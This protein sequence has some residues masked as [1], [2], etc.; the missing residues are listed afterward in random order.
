[1]SNDLTADIDFPPGLVYDLA[2]NSSTFS[3]ESIYDEADIC[4]RWDVSL[5][6]LATLKEH[7]KFVTAVRSAIH[8]LRENGDALR[9]KM[10]MQFE[11]YLETVVPK[12]MAS[13]D[14]KPLEKY[15]FL[16]L[17]SK[18]SGLIDD[19][20]ASKES[21]APPPQQMPTLQIVLTSSQQPAFQ[22]SNSEKVINGEFKKE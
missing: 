12:I 10:R 2:M 9:L 3:G 22:V 16:E 20:K 6:H 8:D 18:G 14:T 1:M 11:V 4:A 13:E 21:A 15:K 17:L 19:T 5:E 7:P